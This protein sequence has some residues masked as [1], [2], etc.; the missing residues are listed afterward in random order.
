VIEVST[1]VIKVL[2]ITLLAVTVLA[3]TVLAVT[4]IKVL[5]IITLGVIRS[6]VAVPHGPF[7][8]HMA[9]FDDYRPLHHYPFLNDDG[10]LNDDGAFNDYRSFDHDRSPVNDNW[11]FDYDLFPYHRSIVAVSVIAVVSILSI[12]ARRPP[13]RL[14]TP[15]QVPAVPQQL[16]HTRIS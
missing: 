11:P 5:T 10:S 2:A 9:S 16:P 14:L 8:N 4:V 7:N 13:G 6:P 3:V 15:A 1:V 12:V